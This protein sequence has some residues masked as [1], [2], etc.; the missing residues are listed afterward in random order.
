TPATVAH[1]AIRRVASNGQFSRARRS[2]DNN[3]VGPRPTC[4]VPNDFHSIS[5]VDPAEAATVRL[6]FDEW[7]NQLSPRLRRVAMLLA[8]GL[9]TVEVAEI[10]GIT[11]GGI[12]M[13]RRELI[14]DYYD[15]FTTGD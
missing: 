5:T 10:V 4:R 9:N 6:H 8:T 11:R 15:R 7:M 14:A 1:F 2:I 13:I 12:S 3:P